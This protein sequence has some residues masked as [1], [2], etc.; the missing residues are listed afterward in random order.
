MKTYTTGETRLRAELIQ[1]NADHHREA[2]LTES[3]LKR[4]PPSTVTVNQRSMKLTGVYKNGKSFQVVK[5]TPV[6]SPWDRQEP[7]SVHF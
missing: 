1:G 4:W 3:S 5:P 6:S 2:A 7:T